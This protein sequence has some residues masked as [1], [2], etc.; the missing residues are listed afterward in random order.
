MAFMRNDGEGWVAKHRRMSKKY[1]H[2][3]SFNK[4]LLS[5]C[6]DSP[7]IHQWVK[8]IKCLSSWSFHNMKGVY[9]VNSH[10]ISE[11]GN[12]FCYVAIQPWGINQQRNVG[13]KGSIPCGRIMV[14]PAKM[15][16]LLQIHQVLC[17]DDLPSS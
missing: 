11:I 10:S 7:R 6:C 8:K 12:Y 13:F 17:N 2:L 1:L 14:F 9:N 16:S 3:C 4:Y 5:A 15:I